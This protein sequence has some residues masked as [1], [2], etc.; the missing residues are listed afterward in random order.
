[1]EYISFVEIENFKGFAEKVHIQ[2]KNP[3]VLIGPNN[4]GKTTVIQALSL[5]SRGVSTWYEKKGNKHK[6]M[7]RV[8]VGINRLNI[9]DIPVKESRY[10]WN[11][12]RVRSGNTPI[13]FSITVGVLIDSHEFPLKMYFNSRDQ[14]SVYCKPDDSIIE[15]DILFQR[16]SKLV[17]NLLYPMS[18]IAAGAS[19]STEEFL[20]SEG[21]I[22]VSIGQGRTASVLRNLCYRV[23]KDSPSDW[24][25]LSG[26][27][28]SLFHV[29]LL[30]P[31]FEETRGVLSLSYTQEEVDTPLDIALSGRGMQ[32]IL[33]ILVYMFSHKQ[34]V[35]MIDEPDAHLEILR[36]RQVFS[37]LKRMA[38]RTACQVIIATHSE[39]ILDEAIDTNLSFL[40][41]G[42]SSDLAE[43]KDIKTML[44]SIGVEH[45]YKAYT[46]PY[47]LIVEGSTDI[48]MLS[49][50]ATKMGHESAKI[51][52]ER[53]FTYYTQDITPENTL[54]SELEK[55]SRPGTNYRL[56]FSTLKKLVPELH[57]LAI[58]DSDGQNRNNDS[59][60]PDLTITYWKKY[61]LEN[62]FISP[63][64]LLA[65]FDKIEGCDENLFSSENHKIMKSAIDK[66]LAGFLFEGNV[67]QVQEYY[68]SSD[69]IRKKL[70]NSIK[71]S[72]FA[73]E[74][75][76]VYAEESRTPILLNKGEFYKI[77]DAVPADQIS[78][79]V[80]EKL[81]LILTILS[82]KQP[83]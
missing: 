43:Q 59:S 81:N 60:I 51:L 52:E 31:V 3:S 21:Q 80:D 30:S 70:L 75:F 54:I 32:Q 69:E 41:N 11:G 16:A 82:P 27:I 40:I 49:A 58:F 25:E 66:T 34:S 47:L 74:V 5:W 18:G 71:M 68:N 19:Q 55:E 22:R 61:E 28:K 39:V 37:I 9:L 67:D 13:P 79:E 20:I 65:Y 56:Y 15:N 62:Y 17:F 57:A 42:K 35:L 26:I 33:L 36:Q 83:R 78:N 72:K 8:S 50:L 10:Y 64:S 38:D 4:A 48:D 29:E 45:Y 7:E 14:E 77:L 53:L 63:E 44:R 46:S 24:T 76:R 23:F 2:L 6:K 12:T 73:E 1:M